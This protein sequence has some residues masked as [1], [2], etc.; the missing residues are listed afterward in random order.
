MKNFQIER[1]QIFISKC[2][3]HDNCRY[4]GTMIS[5]EF[6]KTMKNFVDFI[7][8]CPEMEIGLKSPREAL[9]IVIDEKGTEKLIFSKSGEDISDKM[10]KFSSDMMKSLKNETIHGFILKSRSPSCGIKDVKTYKS[11]GK[12]MTLPKKTQGFF[13]KK[14]MGN[15]ANFPIEDEGRLLNYKIRDNFLT[16]VYLYFDF[17][18]VNTISELV[19]FHSSSKYLIMSYSPSALKK[20]GK[21]VGN[22]DGKNLEIILEEYEKILNNSLSTLQKPSRNVNMIL[23]LFGYFSKKLSKDEKAY[24]LDIL[25]KYSEGKVQFSVPISLIYSWVKRFDEPYLKNQRVF[26]PYPDQLI[27][28]KDSGNR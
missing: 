16:R 18:K 19:E 21:L 24:F 26:F 14:I 6:I 13:G 27:S 9:R 15:Y 20:L 17:K 7:P 11:Y 10:N 12:S 25:E 8:V 3:E 1:P 28:L 2:I 5:S 4:D 23:H 22:H